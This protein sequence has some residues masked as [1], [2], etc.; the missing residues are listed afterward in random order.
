MELEAGLGK[1]EG[2]RGMGVEAHGQG[3][4]GRNLAGAEL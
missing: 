3:R 2:G 4:V 1:W